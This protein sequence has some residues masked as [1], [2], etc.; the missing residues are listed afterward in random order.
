MT[1]P[2]AA[3]L[4][5][6]HCAQGNEREGIWCFSL[7]NG[8]PEQVVK[9]I[10]RRNLFA[11][12]KKGIYF[13]GPAESPAMQ[14]IYYR[15]F[16]TPKPEKLVILKVGI[17]F[18]FGISPNEDAAFLTQVDVENYDILVLDRFR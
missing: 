11:L 17:G 4:G 3:R 6:K 8:K 14:A 5:A 2:P 10:H 9:Q 1:P 7:P 15:D 18:G 16:E 13:V 12:G